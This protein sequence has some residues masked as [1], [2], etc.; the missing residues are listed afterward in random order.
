MKGIVGAFFFEGGWVW[1]AA[2]PKIR[3]GEAKVSNRQTQCMNGGALPSLRIDIS[4]VR[5]RCVSTQSKCAHVCMNDRWGNRR[6]FCEVLVM[7][8]PS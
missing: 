2:H 5:S 7:D 1:L 3:T 6:A 8:V 4:L